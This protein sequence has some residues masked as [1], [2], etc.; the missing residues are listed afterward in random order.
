MEN[1]KGDLVAADT[2]EYGDKRRI[3]R[4]LIASKQCSIDADVV[5]NR[6]SSYSEDGD[7]LA[8][9]VAEWTDKA[10]RRAKEGLTLLINAMWAATC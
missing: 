3:N 4:L 8:I 2:N 5:Y 10:G 6:D 1:V 9:I 7:K